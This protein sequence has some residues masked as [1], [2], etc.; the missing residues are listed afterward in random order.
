VATVDRRLGI[1]RRTWSPAALGL[2]FAEVLNMAVGGNDFYS[3][4][5]GESSSN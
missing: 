2:P 1:R 4:D 3:P 5:E